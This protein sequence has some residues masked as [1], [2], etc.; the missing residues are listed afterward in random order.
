MTGF[1]RADQSVVGRWWWTVDRWTLAAL[2]AIIGIGAIL[3][4]AASPAVASRIGL[5]GFHF[6]KRQLIMLP[7]AIAI[8]F[9]VSMLTPLQIRRLATIGFLIGLGLLALTLVAGAEIKG[10]RRWI[11]AGPLSIQ[12]SEFVKPCFA[13]FAAWMFSEQKKERSIHGNIVA[14]LAY[15]VTVLFLLAQP[16]L[17]MTVVTSAIFLTEFF[18][19][20]LPMIL[21]AI[22]GMLGAV[23]LV[24][25]Y[26]MFPH[27]SS[28]IDRFLDPA[29]G[30]SYQ[31][32]RSLEAFANGGLWGKGPGEG[33][34]K[35][36]IPDVHADF[37]FAVAGE[38]FGLITCLIILSLFAFV[39]L[40][41]F[42]R[43]LQESNLFVLLAASGLLV[44]FGLQAMINM[45]STLHLIPTKGMTLPFISYGGSSLLALALG[46]GM[47]LGLTRRRYGM[48]EL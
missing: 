8:M 4:L 47:L 10:A 36:F 3:M 23:G 26:F 28:R 24:G 13:V 12:P 1:S 44:Q 20:G 39:I 41:G 31:V 16:D 38:E 21:V 27:V 40:R 6:V 11:Q 32:T 19:A 18:L 45:A 37:V 7:P 48:G 14:V 29:A 34:V 5:D 30:D 17:G 35:A 25:A 9:A 2:G 15:G 33:T 22:G 42:G 46:M 43:L